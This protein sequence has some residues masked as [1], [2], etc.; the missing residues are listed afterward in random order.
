M[1]KGRAEVEEEQE[2]PL[3]AVEHQEAAGSE[4]E[5][6]GEASVVVST[7]VVEVG[8]AL[9]AVEGEVSPE[10]EADSEGAGEDSKLRLLAPVPKIFAALFYRPDLCC[11]N[12]L[13]ALVSSPFSFATLQGGENT[14]PLW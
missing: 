4:T 1:V 10:E 8:A 14:S 3:E 2:E 11:I 6:D 12:V 7:R 5:A 13:F 9:V